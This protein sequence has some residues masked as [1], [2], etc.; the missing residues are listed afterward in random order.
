MGNCEVIFKTSW[1]IQQLM[2]KLTPLPC[3]SPSRADFYP[4]MRQGVFCGVLVIVPKHWISNVEQGTA[5]LRRG[6]LRH[7]IFLVRYSA[8]QK[9]YLWT[10]PQQTTGYQRITCFVI[11]CLTRN[12][13]RNK[14]L[15]QFRLNFKWLAIKCRCSII[16]LPNKNFFDF[17]S[18]GS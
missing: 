7:S 14:Y 11:P 17:I 8:V 16:C 6:S 15:I 9:K 1:S 10:T 2:I 12:D 13:N 4:H 5:E 3:P 18:Y